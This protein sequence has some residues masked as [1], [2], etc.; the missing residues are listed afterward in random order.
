[1]P[2]FDQPDV[3]IQAAVIWIERSAHPFVAN[4]GC[5]LHIIVAVVHFHGNDVLVRAEVDERGDVQPERGDAVL[6]LAGKFSVH[7]K[8]AGL[9]ETVK[10]KEDLA[11]AG[12][13]RQLEVLSVPGDAHVLVSL[14]SAVA[15]DLVERVDVVVGVRRADRGPLGIV[16]RG[17]IR[18]LNVLPNELPVGIEAVN[19]TRGR[20]RRKGLI[21]SPTLSRHNKHGREQKP[22]RSFYGSKQQFWHWFHGL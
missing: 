10:L 11:V 12:D 19:R 4:S 14:A 13:S 22:R 6:V 15:D 7:P 8:S 2:G 17:L 1:M 5:F 20:R 3:V 18:T 9:F 16:E 21:H